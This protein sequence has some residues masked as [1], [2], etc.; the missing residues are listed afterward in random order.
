MARRTLPLL[1]VAAAFIVITAFA[2]GAASYRWTYPTIDRSTATNLYFGHATPNPYES[3]ENTNSP[4]TKS[5]VSQEQQL[6]NEVFASFRGREATRK[7]AMQI[8][9]AW[10]DG[11]PQ[12]G[13]FST[14][15]TRARPNRRDVLVVK[16]SS[17]TRAL[18]DPDKRWPDGQTSVDN[19]ALSPD[20]L[21]L[22]YST[23]VHGIETVRWRV[24]DVK[25]GRDLGDVL[26][27]VPDWSAVIWSADSRGLYYGGYSSEAARKDG[28][29][30]GEDFAVRFHRLGRSVDPVVFR[31]SDEPTWILWAQETRDGHYIVLSAV[32]AANGGNFVA[33]IDRT[34]TKASI[35]VVRSMSPS[36]Y[37]FIDSQNSVLYFR[38]N[39]EAPRWKLVAIDLNGGGS[40]RDVIPERADILSSADAADGI[41]IAH[42]LHDAHS[43]LVEFNRSG[44]RTRVVPLPGVGAVDVSAQSALPMF[45]YQFSNLTTPP[46]TFRSNVHSGRNTV[47]SRKVA[48]FDV[49]Q[50]VT[51][52]IFVKSKDGTRIPVFVGHRRNSGRVPAIITGYGF[53]GMPCYI[54]WY[55]VDAIW[56]AKG[57]TFATAC[58]RGGG[59]YGDAWR[60]AGMR[61]NKQ[62]SFD[63]FAASAQALV[64]RG[65]TTY[66]RLVAYGYSAGGLLVGVT[67]VQHPSLFRAVAEEAGPVDVLRAYRYGAEAGWSEETGSPIA[68]E[69]EFK[70]L[71]AYAPLLAIKPSTSYPATFILTNENDARVSPA[72]SYK[73]AATLQWAQASNAP[74]VLYV[75]QGGHL[76]GTLGSEAAVLTD[77]E[78][79]LW[80][81]TSNGQ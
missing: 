77:T 6:T 18:I 35:R 50:L 76:G 15:W 52:E 45:Y 51:D 44:K 11:L 81:E 24:I 63:D 71:A 61:G 42:Y 38:T 59:D 25:T 43:E 69:Q 22:A 23:S 37:H 62:N 34:N 8:G 33:V 70:W 12:V 7:I 58:V 68:S 55:P 74:I 1:L 47:F 80:N 5:W 49:S 65:F 32:T 60:R 78:T 54:R 72:H 79:F 17:G 36:A 16:T 64:T 14:A 67:E 26:K 28:V 27:G 39:H 41:F 73:F 29:P 56:L 75:A 21:K 57:G 13:R 3:L 30:I 31:R 40:E 20:G 9:T 19:W 4:T 66:R 10:Q 48:P 46:I 53:A 2:G